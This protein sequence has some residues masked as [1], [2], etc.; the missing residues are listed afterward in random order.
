VG[1]NEGAGGKREKSAV[2]DNERF[3]SLLLRFDGGAKPN[4][5]PAGAGAVL[6][7][8]A[9]GAEHKVWEASV[10]I[11][12]RHSNNVAEYHA[13]IVGLRAARK[14]LAPGGRLKIIGDSD[15][16]VNQVNGKFRVLKEHLKPLHAAAKELLASPA[17]AYWELLHQFR[18]HN[19]VCDKLANKAIESRKTECWPKHILTPGEL[20]LASSS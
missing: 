17:I 1:A 13:A 5:G 20:K 7:A 16:V 9:G 14:F 4:P 15:L 10:F 8:L 12:E 18:K 2:R 6:Y 19:E 3:K 11:G